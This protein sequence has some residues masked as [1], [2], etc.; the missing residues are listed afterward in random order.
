MPSYEIFLGHNIFLENKRIVVLQQLQFS[1]SIE[2]IEVPVIEPSCILQQLVICITCHG[3]HRVLFCKVVKYN[4]SF[5]HG[6]TYKLVQILISN[7]QCQKCSPTRKTR[8]MLL[9]MCEIC[10][11]EVQSSCLDFRSVSHIFSQ[12]S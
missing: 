5:V 11:T 4:I 9:I 7:G 8:S 10:L 1:F 3:V 2:V 12:V 6:K